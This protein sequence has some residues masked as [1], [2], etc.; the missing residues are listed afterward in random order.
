MESSLQSISRRLARENPYTGNSRQDAEVYGYA[1]QI[2]LLNVTAL[3]GIVMFSW[4]LGTVKTTLTLWAAAFSLRLF[5][6]GRHRSGPVTCWLTT[7]IVFTLLGYL[8]HTFAHRLGEYVL[9]VVA[10]GLVF[11]LFTVINSA[12]V[13]VAGKQ[14]PE[15]KKRQL[16]MASVAVVVLWAIMALAPLQSIFNQP[17]PPLSITAGLVVQSLFILSVGNLQDR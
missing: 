11:A 9:P 15:P 5:A 6:G 8:V 3:T 13:L 16:K 14:F 17:V 1:L 2:L 12:P 7:V 4:L 10:L